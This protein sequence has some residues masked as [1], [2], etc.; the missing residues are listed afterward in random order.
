MSAPTRSHGRKS[1]RPLARPTELMAAPD[2]P[3]PGVWTA[4]VIT[5]FPEAFPGVLG[6]SLTGRALAEGL[7]RLQTTDLRRFGLGRHRAVDDTPVGGG[8]GMVLRADVLDAALA[9]ACAGTPTDP[10]RWP[11]V[12]LSP[13]GAP[14]TQARAQAWS[15]AQGLTLVCGRFEGIDER[16]IEARGLQEISIGDFVL[17]GGEIAAQALI[18]ARVGI[19]PGGL[20][21][22]GAGA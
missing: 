8:P 14:F 6:A 18:D 15:R 4:R 11:R 5:L 21:N 17:T 20:G 16:V 2:M 3:A 12:V 13:R 1:A 10:A 9:E 19:K 7:W 22:P